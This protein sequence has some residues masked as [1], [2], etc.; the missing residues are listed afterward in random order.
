MKIS[1]ARSVSWSGSRVNVFFVWIKALPLVP[2]FCF[3]AKHLPLAL[4]HVGNRFSAEIIC[5]SETVITK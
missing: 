5:P 1:S 2:A 4:L 3:G